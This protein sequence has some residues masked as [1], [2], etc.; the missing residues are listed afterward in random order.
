MRTIN[1]ENIIAV[2]I[3]ARQVKSATLFTIEKKVV[4]TKENT[5]K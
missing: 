3:E 2:N 5:T 4:P 1:F